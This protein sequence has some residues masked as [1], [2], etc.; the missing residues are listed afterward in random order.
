M[1]A[2]RKT[3]K[4]FL[5]VRS[6]AFTRLFV[7]PPSAVR[8]KPRKRGTTNKSKWRRRSYFPQQT[9]YF[10]PLPHGHGSLR[11]TFGPVRFGFGFS[12]ES[13]SAASLTISLF[14]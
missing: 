11:P 3:R 14:L 6:S 7:V 10:F 9:L 1:A 13:S 2:H 5:K 8:R 4:R 12:F